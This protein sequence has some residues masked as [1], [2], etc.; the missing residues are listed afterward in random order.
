MILYYVVNS[1]FN[2]DTDEAK[3]CHERDDEDSYFD[4]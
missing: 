4:D 2:F 1:I 3:G